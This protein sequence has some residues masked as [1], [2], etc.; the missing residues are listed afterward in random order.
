MLRR[1]PVGGDDDDVDAFSV[2][3]GPNDNGVDVF[4]WS[5]A[6]KASSLAFISLLCHIFHDG[7]QI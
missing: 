6:T 1:A 5:V 2:C 3:D 7:S 4:S